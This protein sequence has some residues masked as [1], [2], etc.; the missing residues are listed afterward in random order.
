MTFK[1]TYKYINVLPHFVRGYNDAVQSA[2]GMAPSKVTDSDILAIWKRMRSKHNAIRRAAV[3]FSVG[4]HV[5]ISKE[6]LKFAKGGEQNY[7]TEV[8]RISEVVRP[9]QRPVYEVQSLLGKHIAGQFYAK[10]LRSV[11]ATKITTYAIHKILR[12]RLKDGILEY[13]VRWKRYSAAFDSWIKAA[14]AKHVK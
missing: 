14:T 4:Q 8:I 11:L 5:R 1:N 10:E 13:L 3:R 7:T 2:T 6:K 9:D 12:T